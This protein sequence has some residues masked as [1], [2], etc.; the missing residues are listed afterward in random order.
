M[1]LKKIA[2]RGM[3]ILAAIVALCILFAGTLRSLTTPKVDFAEVKNG[4]FEKIEI[5]RASC[6][7]RV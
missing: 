1:R 6:R 3:I 5:G 7:E 4:K 2:L